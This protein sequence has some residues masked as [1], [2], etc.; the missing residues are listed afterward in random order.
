[1]T[2][3]YFNEPFHGAMWELSAG[4]SSLFTQQLERVEGAVS[5]FKQLVLIR[6]VSDVNQMN[7]AI[8]I[9]CQAAG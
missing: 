2:A 8:V 9:R 1:M 7:L 4:C 5:D 3:A 6:L